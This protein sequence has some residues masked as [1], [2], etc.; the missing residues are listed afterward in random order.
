[1]LLPASSEFVSLCR[2]QIALLIQ[3]LGAHQSAIYLSEQLTD[4]GDTTLTPIVFYPEGLKNWP[5]S[6]QW[7]LP[8]SHPNTQS[9][10]PLLALGPS[11]PTELSFSTTAKLASSTLD[12]AKLGTTKS[13]TLKK[14]DTLEVNTTRSDCCDKFAGRQA[15][16][17]SRCFVWTS[18][19]ERRHRVRD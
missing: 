4:N 19:L 5:D 12:T 15:P 9:A 11:T 3:G 18:A 13:D 8:G 2:S 17:M 14:S 7:Q 1:M 10:N 6:I 16:P